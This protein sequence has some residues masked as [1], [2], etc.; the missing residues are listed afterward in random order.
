MCY[1][2]FH[3]ASLTFYSFYGVF[4]QSEVVAC[5]H[6][7]SLHL[8]P[9]LCNPMDHSPPGS[10]VQ[11]I[12]QARLPEWVAVPSSRGISRTRGLNWGLLCLLP[13]PAG[14]L[15]LAPPGKP[16]KLLVS[17]LTNVYFP[18]QLVLFESCLINHSLSKRKDG[19]FPQCLL[20][21]F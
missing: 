17:M 6:A 4:E 19:I 13:W 11:G 5:V 20:K 9:T 8:C 10:S 16:Q 12:L 15:L 7:K 2:H 3:A 18:L 14:S 1:K 21:G